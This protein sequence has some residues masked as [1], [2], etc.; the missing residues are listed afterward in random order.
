MEWIQLFAKYNILLGTVFAYLGNYSIAA[1]LLLSGLKT[2]ALNLFL[3][4]CDFI[5]YILSR[6]EEIPAEDAEYE[7]CGFSA[8]LPMGGTDP[9]RGDLISNMA[10][11]VISGLEGD[12]GEIVLAHRGSHSYGSITRLGSTASEK[13]RNCIDMYEVLVAKRDFTVKRVRFYFN[14]YFTRGNRSEVRLPR[15]FHLDP[16]SIAAE[17]LT[18]VR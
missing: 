8:D 1:Y 5:A 7:G 4:Y 3:P 12:D 10:E 15:G 6:V 18:P 9:D 16:M 14:G 13:H 11:L 2:R 17:M